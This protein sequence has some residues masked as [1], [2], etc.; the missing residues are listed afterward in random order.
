MSQN[1]ITAL[2]VTVVENRGVLEDNSNREKVDD[3]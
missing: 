2:E 3:K 1:D